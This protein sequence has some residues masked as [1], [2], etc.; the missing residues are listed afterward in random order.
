MFPNRLA[1]SAPLPTSSAPMP[2]WTN[3]AKAGL[4][5][6]VLAAFTTSTR[7]PIVLAAASTSRTSTSISARFG[8]SNT[9]ISLALGIGSHIDRG[10][11]HA[12]NV[13]AR[14]IETGPPSPF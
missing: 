14:T 5:S 10:E 3:V 7:R 12:G 6:P 11:G 13:A 8:S 4:N 1:R 9:P 2:A